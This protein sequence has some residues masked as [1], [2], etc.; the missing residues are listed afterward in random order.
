[1]PAVINSRLLMEISHPSLPTGTIRI[2]NFNREVDYPYKNLVYRYND[3]DLSLAGTGRQLQFMNMAYRLLFRATNSRERPDF[4]ILDWVLSSRG[5]RRA[6]V[7]SLWINEVGTDTHILQVR[8]TELVTKTII[9]YL[10]SA[11]DAVGKRVP[12]I[13][14]PY[15][16]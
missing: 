11:Q 7:R 3:F 9:F 5:L 13:F 4:P 10:Q 1:M 14:D 15:V 12:N 8:R 2:Q 16:L 6:I